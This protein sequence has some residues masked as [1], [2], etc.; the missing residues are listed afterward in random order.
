MPN[1]VFPNLD[2]V[3]LTVNPTAVDLN[4]TTNSTCRVFK[5]YI[6]VV[7]GVRFTVPPLLLTYYLRFNFPQ[8]TASLSFGST[9]KMLNSGVATT[10]LSYCARS[11]PLIRIPIFPALEAF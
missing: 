1:P 6:I 3:N 10:I 7:S 9:G 8:V 2:N 11:P 4:Y 5:S